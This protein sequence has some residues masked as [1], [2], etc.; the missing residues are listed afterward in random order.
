MS[1]E[2]LIQEFKNKYG[3][4]GI[5]TKPIEYMDYEDITDK[6]EKDFVKAIDQTREETIRE[7][8][9]GFTGDKKEEE[10]TTQEA[11]F[12]NMERWGYNPYNQ[13]KNH[14]KL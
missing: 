8:E 5:H 12:N 7:V 3:L 14:L 2:T 6:V 1:K 11:C 4:N 13:Y 10:L 9:E